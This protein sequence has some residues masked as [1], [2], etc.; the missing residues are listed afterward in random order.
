MAEDRF[1]SGKKEYGCK[2]LEKRAERESLLF[3][4]AS[5]YCNFL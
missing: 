1:S 5:F 3:F 4:I 2:A